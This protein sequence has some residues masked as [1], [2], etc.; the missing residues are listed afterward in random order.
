MREARDV[1]VPLPYSRAIEPVGD[2]SAVH[3][4]TDNL[5]PLPNWEKNDPVAVPVLRRTSSCPHLC[6]WDLRVIR[7]GKALERDSLVSGPGAS[8][9][10]VP[11]AAEAVPRTTSAHGDA[12]ATVE[13]V[14]PVVE[15]GSQGQG[16]RQGTHLLLQHRT[17]TPVTIH[18]A[19]QGKVYRPGLL[20]RLGVWSQ[21][22]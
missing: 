9:S 4:S 14:S 6:P 20:A 22:T 17:Y 16:D 13:S 5:N 12:E 15:E 8:D 21:Q 19:C 11:A 7:Q 10:K 1:L 18:Q 3:G 2:Y